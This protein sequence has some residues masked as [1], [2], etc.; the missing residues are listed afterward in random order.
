MKKWFSSKKLY[1]IDGVLDDI[2]G[3]FCWQQ[4]GCA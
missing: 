2:A 1:L 3:Y 4:V